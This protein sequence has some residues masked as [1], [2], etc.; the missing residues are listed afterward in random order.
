MLPK[1][2]I[3]TANIFVF[4]C[5]MMHKNLTSKHDSPN[6]YLMLGR[7]RRWWSDIKLTLGQRLVLIV[8]V[9]KLCIHD[10]LNSKMKKCIF[11]YVDL[12]FILQ[13]HLSL[14]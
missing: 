4:Y 5:S 10:R 8:R 7:H 3:S 12:F 2:F 13:L 11:I 9:A 1:P 6:V 14:Y